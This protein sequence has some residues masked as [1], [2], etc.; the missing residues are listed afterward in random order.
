MKIG[1][2]PIAKVCTLLGGLCGFIMAV[3]LFLTA[4]RR[5]GT[6]ACCFG[7]LG[8]LGGAILITGF[9][10]AIQT[11]DPSTYKDAVCNTKMPGLNFKTGAEVS[12]QMNDEFVNKLMCSVDCP[13]ADDW[14]EIIEEEIASERGKD[15][16]KTKY[17]RY[18]EG[19]NSSPQP[20]LIPMKF[21]TEDDDKVKKEYTS[22]EDCFNEQFAA[23][24]PGNEMYNAAVS[25]Y[26]K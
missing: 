2:N 20:G 25:N 19:N 9:V 13:C 21:G 12:K 18:F 3:L 14:K 4:K 24:G 16:L 5:T 6:F 1:D 17:K 15:E 8:L 22:M 7:L 26:K 10:F 11:K 23:K